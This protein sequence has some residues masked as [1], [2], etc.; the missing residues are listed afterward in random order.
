[1]KGFTTVGSINRLEKEVDDLKNVPGTTAAGVSYDNTS[2]GLTADD[3]QE[4]IDELNTAIGQIN[5][6]P[7]NYSETEHE[8]GTWID[9]SKLYEKTLEIEFSDFTSS[10]DLYTYGIT[11]LGETIRNVFG[12]MNSTSFGRCLL[13]ARAFGASSS[14]ESYYWEFTTYY[15]YVALF[16]KG[17]LMS[18]VGPTTGYVTIQYTKDEVAPA[19]NT[20]K[21]SSKK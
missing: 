14:V 17:Q 4:A 11:T 5:P 10:G 6:L 12:L 3:V 8:V 1:M 18:A 21:K 20:R 15:G 7:F 13:G 2:S 16:S 9:G 19:E